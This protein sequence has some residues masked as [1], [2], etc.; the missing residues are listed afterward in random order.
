VATRTLTILAAAC[1]L[2]ACAG[3]GATPEPPPA[4]T[5]QALP[6]TGGPRHAGDLVVDAAARPALETGRRL[7]LHVNGSLDRG[8]RRTWAGIE[9]PDF[10]ELAAGSAELSLL[11][12]EGDTY[13]ALYREP[14][15]SGRCSYEKPTDCRLVARLYV[16]NGTSVEVVLND[17]LPPHAALEVQDA[18]LADGVLYFNQVCDEAESPGA[19]ELAACGTVTALQL[20]PARVLWRSVPF[21]SKQEFRLRGSHVLTAYNRAAAPDSDDVYL[22][23]RADG[24]VVAS[25]DVVRED[26]FWGFKD[27]PDGAVEVVF[28]H[29]SLALDGTALE[30]GELVS[31]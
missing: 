13:F 5:S 28:H 29:L 8:E 18:R 6:A 30:R 10:V 22:L 20:Q 4:R 14:F 26:G 1:T 21:V 19:G 17:F 12:R 9:V 23:Q 2:A 11:D 24:R 15:G 25:R 31:R 16:A 27:R 7:R 3:T